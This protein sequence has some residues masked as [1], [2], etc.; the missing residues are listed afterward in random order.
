MRERATKIVVKEATPSEIL[1][2]SYKVE[3]HHIKDWG[4][5]DI[6]KNQNGSCLVCRSAAK[7]I[8]EGVLVEGRDF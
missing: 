3:L 7:L 4:L 2:A 1:A 8:L 5:E 6:M